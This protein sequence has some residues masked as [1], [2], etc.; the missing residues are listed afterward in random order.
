[1]TKLNNSNKR[2]EDEETHNQQ[3]PENRIWNKRK[4]VEGNKNCVINLVRFIIAQFVAMTIWN[5]TLYYWQRAENKLQQI[6]I[7]TC[8]SRPSLTYG[9][10]WLILKNDKS[11]NSYLYTDMKSPFIHVRARQFRIKKFIHL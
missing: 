3:W 10:K 11:I 5:L 8:V 9:R 1:M 6:Y 2:G 7:K 4:T